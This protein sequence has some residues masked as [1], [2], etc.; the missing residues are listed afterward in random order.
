LVEIP[1]QDIPNH[2]KLTAIRIEYLLNNKEKRFGYLTENKI[3]KIRNGD[4]SN[5]IGVEFVENPRKEIVYS[6]I[7]GVI[8][9]N[10]L[11]IVSTTKSKTKV[12]DYNKQMM[13]EDSYELNK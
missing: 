3:I 5:I 2:D 6:K 11:V 1:F 10:N 9:N 8:Q 7:I 12:A 4:L 13:F